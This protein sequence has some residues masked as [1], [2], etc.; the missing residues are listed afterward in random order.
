M[1]RFVDRF[2]AYLSHLCSLTEDCSVMSSD[3]QKLKGC[4][5]KWQNG[6]ML[7]GC[8]LIID[9]LKPVAILS[10]SLQ[11]MEVNAVEAIEGI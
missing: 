6:K 3:K 1:N 5:L 9:L 7:L 10:K 8:V 2:G 4:I 11:C